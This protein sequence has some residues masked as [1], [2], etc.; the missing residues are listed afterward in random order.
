MAKDVNDKDL[1][2]MFWSRHER[3]PAIRG[4]YFM[5]LAQTWDKDTLDLEP[6]RVTCE[7]VENMVDD[8]FPDDR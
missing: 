6:E 4:I 7:D 5:P 2:D 3:C 1:P 8:A